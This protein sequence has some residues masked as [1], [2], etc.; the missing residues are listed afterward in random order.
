MLF[1][2]EVVA[3]LGAAG[4]FIYAY[5]SRAPAST[6][7]SIALGLFMMFEPIKKLSRVHLQLQESLSGAE[8]IFEVIDR[9]PSVIEQPA[10]ATMPRFQRELQ[11]DRV[12]FGYTQDAVLEDVSFTVPAGALT[13]IVG[14][15]GAG[16]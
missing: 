5:E 15:S 1:R 16:K 6:L 13:A 8:R 7:V 4:V 9:Q 14:A 2:S 12:G 11:F 10:A 3:G